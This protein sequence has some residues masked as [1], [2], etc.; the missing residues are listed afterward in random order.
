VDTDADVIALVRSTTP[1]AA[2]ASAL[3]A[4]H[5]AFRSAVVPGGDHAFIADENGANPFPGT[6]RSTPGCHSDSYEVFILLGTLHEPGIGSCPSNLEGSSTPR[7]GWAIGRGLVGKGRSQ[8]HRLGMEEQEEDEGDAGKK[9]FTIRFK[10]AFSP[11]DARDNLKQH[12]DEDDE[13]LVL[14]VTGASWAGAGFEQSAY[15]WLS[16]SI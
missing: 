14:R 15:D 16:N 8:P 1:G 6:V 7:Q 12:I 4:V 2:L 11:T 13:L 3:V 5:H 9:T 10:S